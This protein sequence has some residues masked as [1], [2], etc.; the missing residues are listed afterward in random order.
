MVLLIYC[1][2]CTMVPNIILIHTENYSIWSCFAGFFLP[3][4][5]YICYGVISRR[6]GTPV[7]CLIWAMFFAAFQ[8]VLSYLFGNS[9]IAT[10]MFVNLFTTNPNEASELLMNIAP[11]VGLVI[12][13]YLP[14]IAYA[15]YAT[16]KHYR[17]TKKCRRKFL[18][19]GIP[20]MLLGALM[21]IPARKANNDKSVFLSEI[22]PANVIYNFKLCI[23]IQHAVRSYHTTSKDFSYDASRSRSASQREIYVYVIGEAARAANWSAFGYERET[24][25]EL[26][27]RED[28]VIFRNMITQSN[29][30][31]KSV[32]LLLS[33]VSA[34]NQPEIYRRK[35]ILK[36]FHEAGFK[37]YFISDQS[38]QGGMIDFLGNEADETTFISAPRYDIQ[39]LTLMRRIIDDDS[40]NNLFFV[41]HCYGSHFAYNQRYPKEMSFF[42]PDGDCKI[43]AANT[44]LLRN[45]Y[46]N[47]IRYTDYVLNS[48]IEYLD[49]KE[50]CSAMFF[51]SDHGEDLFDD[52]RGRFLHA[53]PTVTY[54]QLHVPALVWFSRQ[55]TEEFPTKVISAKYNINAP[56]TTHSAFH[57]LADIANIESEYCDTS[58]SLVSAEFSLL[59]RRYYLNDHNEAVE[60]D[61]RIGINKHDKELFE[62]AG[63]QL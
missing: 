11:A 7:L 2:V 16:H 14:I 17:I 59:N 5:F 1:L 23:S 46:D 12:V 31:H 53:S 42:K 22:F 8:I 29:T 50:C 37:T 21:L 40:N 35:G 30:T 13:M 43:S 18:Q 48:I 57:T 55:Y 32:P 51:C 34:E 25:P 3:L 19:V 4:G 39:L 61:S 20:M 36:L 44:E 26:Q 63:I 62:K 15:T 6:T 49:T 60:F 56:A 27:K 52:K 10:D 33:S 9:I 38:P 47:S 41:L 45:T 28:V 58:V 24:T 54:Y